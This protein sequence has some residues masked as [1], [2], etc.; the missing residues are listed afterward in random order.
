MF[1]NY[2]ICR[3][4]VPVW[5]YHKLNGLDDRY[6]VHPCLYDDQK[7]TF[8]SWVDEMLEIYY[9]LWEL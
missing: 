2:I 5:R 3:P 4:V 8:L 9:V 1:N 6:N 7:Y